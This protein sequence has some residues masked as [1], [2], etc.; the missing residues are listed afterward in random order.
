MAS[1]MHTVMPYF[2]FPGKPYFPLLAQN[3]ETFLSQSP[4]LLLL[5]WK[6]SGLTS[7]TE[8]NIFPFLLSSTITLNPLVRIVRFSLLQLQWKANIL[9][10]CT[11]TAHEK[12]SQ[13]A[14]QLFVKESH[15]VICL[16]VTTAST[17]QVQTIHTKSLK[18]QRWTTAH[19]GKLFSM[20]VQGLVHM[21]IIPPHIWCASKSALFLLQPQLRSA[22]KE[23]LSEYFFPA[24]L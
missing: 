20:G 17:G 8:P 4:L 9:I 18:K 13:K 23:R 21:V 12:L 5:S 24:Y 3:P 15:L 7:M 10:E 1:Q 14:T 11:H 16:A 19:A 22:Q 6:G 2:F